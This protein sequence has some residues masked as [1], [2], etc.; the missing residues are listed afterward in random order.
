MTCLTPRD[1]GINISFHGDMSAVTEKSFF[2]KR[3][4]FAMA[5]AESKHV[6]MSFRIFDSQV[7][8]VRLLDVRIYEVNYWDSGSCKLHEGTILRV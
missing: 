2:S 4:S 6:V 8:A 5:R 7:G 3:L 1:S